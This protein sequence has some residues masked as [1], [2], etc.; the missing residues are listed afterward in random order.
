MWPFGE[1]AKFRYS[2]GVLLF[3]ASSSRLFFHWRCLVFVPIIPVPA[4][5][6]V[7]CRSTI[8]RCSLLVS[9]KRTRHSLLSI[10]GHS[11]NSF[12][13][14]VNKQW[15]NDVVKTRMAL[16]SVLLSPLSSEC[17]NMPD[18]RPIFP[19]ILYLSHLGLCS[20]VI[21]PSL[22]YSIFQTDKVRSELW[23]S[24]KRPR[25]RQQM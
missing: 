6:L 8:K 19:L 16:L 2:V 13:W 14:C 4:R 24:G 7:P 5:S 18:L 10:Q 17:P 11:S 12:A 25:D 9:S 3:V 20:A 1:E 23:R 21:Q 22:T 15:L